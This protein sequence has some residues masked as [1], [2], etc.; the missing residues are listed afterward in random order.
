MSTPPNRVK[1]DAMGLL[2]LAAAEGAGPSG[3]GALAPHH[4]RHSG[5]WRGQAQGVVL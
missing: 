3:I 4:L 2:H 5:D 1:T